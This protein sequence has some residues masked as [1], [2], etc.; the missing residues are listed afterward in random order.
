MTIRTIRARL[1][2]TDALSR[3]GGPLQAGQGNPESTPWWRIVALIAAGGLAIRV[4]YVLGW[5]VDQL[6][7]DP[8][9]YHYG[10]NLLADGHGFVEPNRFRLGTVA[11]GADHPPGFVV[12]LALGS[13]VG[14]RSVLSHQVLCCF[15]GTITIVVIAWTARRVVGLRTGLIAAGLAAVYPNIWMYDAYVMSE[16][17]IFL[18]TTLTMLASLRACERPTPARFAQIGF[19]IG[20]SALTRAEAIL[21]LPLI[22]LPLLWR[23]KTGAHRNAVLLGAVATLATLV[24][25]APWIGYN[26]SRFDRPV[27]LTDTAE[28]GLLI[29]NCDDVYYGS[30]IGYWSPRCEYVT[31]R[32]APDDD[33]ARASIERDTAT[34]YIRSHLS[35]V[36]LVVL[37][38]V[39]RTY[40]LYDPIGQLSL[41]EHD[42]LVVRREALP[43]LVGFLSY[44]PLTVG[45]ISGLLLLRK[46][47]RPTFFLIAPFVSVAITVVVLYGQTRF[48]AAAE[49]TLVI[50]AAAALDRVWTR[51]HAPLT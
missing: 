17:L 39:G 41:D 26:L 48:R 13:V 16:T 28:I 25:V 3:R 5:R 23:S 36:P 44:Y 4:G 18:T 29:S 32:G 27:T 1:E 22:V 9:Y 50:L 19:L 12:L 49:P 43:A 6:G 40:G 8:F 30:N 37:A 45:A 51:R 14:L 34:R 20:V 11:P 46:T 38:R 35:R 24:V 7:S 10:A 15:V 21:L 42:D 2:V 33:V 47:G 31:L